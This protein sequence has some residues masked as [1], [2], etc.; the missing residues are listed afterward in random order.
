MPESIN[1]RG[2]MKENIIK[3][4]GLFALLLFLGGFRQYPNHSKPFLQKQSTGYW[5]E[6][7]VKNI[8]SKNTDYRHKEIAV[9]WA[10]NNGADSWQ[11]FADCS[12]FINSLL[13][14]TY[15]W[16]DA[17]FKRW[18]GKNRPLA[19][20]YFDAIVAENHF[21]QIHSI[22]EIQPG[23]L[24]V[25]KYSD[26]SEHEDNTGHC[27]LVAKTPERCTAGPVTEPSTNQYEVTVI[28]C[29]KSPHGKTDTRYLNNGDEYP[30]LGKGVFRLYADRKGNITAYSW[31]KGRPKPGFDPYANP[32]VVG[33]IS[34]E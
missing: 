2:S 16:D 12:G 18:L 14:Q 13:K 24:I 3:L 10:G 17:Y 19:Y 8:S 29:S 23:D 31:S 9:T 33:R 5:A 32:V 27:M 30:G 1:K 20:H 26:R 15:G 21:K 28:D 22:D 11:C 7:L 4:S 6:M 34:I 25:L